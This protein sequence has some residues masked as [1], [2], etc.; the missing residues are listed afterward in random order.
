MVN[1]IIQKRVDLFES[2]IRSHFIREQ[3]Y[4]VY[5]IEV[6]K[7]LEYESQL[8]PFLDSLKPYYYKNKHYYLERWPLHYNQFNTVLRQLFNKNEMQVEKKVKYTMS[9]YQVEYYVFLHD[10]NETMNEEQ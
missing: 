5:N 8:K 10:D 3:D 9:K 2:F 7:K 4:Y 6:F 1:Q